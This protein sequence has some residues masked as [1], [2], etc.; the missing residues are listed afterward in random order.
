MQI[1][2]LWRRF[3]QFWMFLFTCSLELRIKKLNNYFLTNSIKDS[4]FHLMY[5]FKNYVNL[6]EIM[7]LLRPIFNVNKK[8][9]LTQCYAAKIS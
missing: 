4:V 8:K 2:I 7:L 6:I 3:L 9:I 1:C 5:A